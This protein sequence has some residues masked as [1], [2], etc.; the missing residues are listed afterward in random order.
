MRQDNGSFVGKT[1]MRE[2]CGWSRVSK[3]QSTEREHLAVEGPECE[4]PL[5][6]CSE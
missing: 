3:N 1:V 5:W 6:H 4:K 2:Q